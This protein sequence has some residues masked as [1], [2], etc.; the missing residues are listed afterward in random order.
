MVDRRPIGPEAPAFDPGHVG[1]LIVGQDDAEAIS[2]VSHRLESYET[3]VN[4]V[5]VLAGRADWAIE[6]DRKDLTDLT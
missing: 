3:E 6:I 1:A 4:P 2:V 5:G